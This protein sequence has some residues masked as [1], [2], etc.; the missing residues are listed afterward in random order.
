MV[1]RKKVI[2]NV[3]F[4]YSHQFGVLD[5]C[6]HKC[7][8]V[9]TQ[10]GDGSD[11]KHA[12]MKQAPHEQREKW[13]DIEHLIMGQEPREEDTSFAASV[14]TRVPTQQIRMKSPIQT[15]H[16]RTPRGPML[17]STLA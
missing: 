11:I 10:A 13:R 15:N 7:E 6:V 17:G 3:L 12:L 1:K 8:N 14:G 9:V 5:P 4:F 16:F 2:S